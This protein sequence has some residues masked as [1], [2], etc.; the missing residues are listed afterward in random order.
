VILNC[1]ENSFL[2]KDGNNTVTTLHGIRKP[3]YVRQILAMKFKKYINKG[4]K[5]YV[6]QVTNLLEK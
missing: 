6:I 4:C 1:Y 3:I 2:Y 5:V